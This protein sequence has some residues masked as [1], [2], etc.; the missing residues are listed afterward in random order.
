[1]SDELFRLSYSKLASYDQ[2]RKK[3]WYGYISF[4][5]R[6]P[7]EGSVA[8]IVGTGVHQAMKVLGDT[9]DADAARHDLDVYLRMPIHAEA[10]P[11]TEPHRLAFELLDSGVAAHRSIASENTW[12]E[13]DTWVPSAGLGIAVTARLDRAD[14]LS[15]HE[16]QIIDW[17]TGKFDFGE[18]TDAQ[19]DIAH[20]VLR[21][22]RKLK[23][24]DTVTGIGWNLR[25][26]ERRVRPLT[27]DDAAATMRYLAGRARQLQA[28]TEFEATPSRMCSFCDWRSQCPEAAAVETPLDEWWE[29][30][31]SIDD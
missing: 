28:T 20:L 24:E 26:G 6:D 21:T 30:D 13:L 19:L 5:P 12:T 22:A 3:Y 31:V 1:M 23:R 10:G 17:K 11:G 25:T 29:E 15:E 8:G 7:D 14:R 18:V 9:D 16:Y 2:C 4:T 27:R